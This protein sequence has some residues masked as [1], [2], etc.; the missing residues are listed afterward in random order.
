[1]NLGSPKYGCPLHLC[2]LKHKFKLAMEVLKG[3][4]VNVHSLNPNGSNC[5]HILFANYSFGEGEESKQLANALIAHGID[6]NLVDNNGLSPI[7]VAI[8]K[9]QIEAL[10]YAVNY[11]KRADGTRGGRIFEFNIHGKKGFTPLHYSI[12]KANHEAFMYLLSDECKQ[13]V[14]ILEMDEQCR[15]PK[16]LALINSPFYRIL[17]GLEKLEFQRPRPIPN[18]T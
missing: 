15:T 9:N 14:N 6:M 3:D 11:N 5:L 1:M 12:I 8:K 4:K 10:R 13:F 18:T 7:H 2:I 17:L 16:Q